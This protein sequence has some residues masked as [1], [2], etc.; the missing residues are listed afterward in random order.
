[1]DTVRVPSLSFHGQGNKGPE[2]VRSKSK[3][4]QD[5]RPYLHLEEMS[6]QKFGNEG[7]VALIK[8]AS[9]MMTNDHINGGSWDTGSSRPWY[10][11]CLGGVGGHW[12]YS[13]VLGT[14]DVNSELESWPISSKIHPLEDVINQHGCGGQHQCP[15]KLPRALTLEC[16]NVCTA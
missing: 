10:F 6:S 11:L 1:M 4:T 15:T 16:A 12:R 3:I 8:Q 7:A 5:G 13:G 9:F 2:K 14:K